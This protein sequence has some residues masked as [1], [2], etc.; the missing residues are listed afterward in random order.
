MKN[1]W[2]EAYAQEIESYVEDVGARE[3]SP[4]ISAAA[5]RL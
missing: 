3:I 2:A 1:A 4:F 5:R